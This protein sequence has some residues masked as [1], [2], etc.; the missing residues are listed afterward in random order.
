MRVRDSLKLAD[1]GCRLR[2]AEHGNLVRAASV[3]AEVGRAEAA[4]RVQARRGAAIVTIE[5]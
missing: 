2:R 3:K 5:L 1:P 4:S